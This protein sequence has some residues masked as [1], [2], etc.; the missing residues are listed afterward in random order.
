MAWIRTPIASGTIFATESEPHIGSYSRTVACAVVLHPGYDAEP[1][2]FPYLHGRDDL[3]GDYRHRALPPHRGK[4][5]SGDPRSC[6]VK[7]LLS[8]PLPVPDFILYRRR[9]CSGWRNGSR[10]RAEIK[11]TKDRNSRS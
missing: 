4:F 1:I 11:R 9:S 3:T 10:W 7:Q 8:R 2:V 6:N 5:A